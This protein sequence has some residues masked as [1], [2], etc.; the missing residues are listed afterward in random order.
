MLD[1]LKEQMKNGDSQIKAVGEILKEACESNQAVADL[2]E[3]DLEKPEMSLKK[4][5]EKMR[6]TAKKK[7]KGGCYYMSPAEAEKIIR[8]FYG[9][10]MHRDEPK[11]MEAPAPS[12]TGILDLADLLEL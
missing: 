6:E 11:K 2:V 8:E 5:F 9:L 7:Q 10:P 3:Q 4:C 12:T 1:N